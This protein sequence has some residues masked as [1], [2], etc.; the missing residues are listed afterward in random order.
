MSPSEPR[1]RRYAIPM[2]R[3]LEMRRPKQQSPIMGGLAMLLC[4][5]AG[6]G[7]QPFAA[8]FRLTKDQARQK[9]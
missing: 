7:E 4:R 2:A 3:M 8:S 5:K 9:F 6:P 1:E